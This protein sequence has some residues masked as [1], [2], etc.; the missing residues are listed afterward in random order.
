VEQ[1]KSI[2]DVTGE[3]GDIKSQLGDLVKEV[4]GISLDMGV[5]S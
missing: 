5:Y 1:L 4:S 3:L 2:K